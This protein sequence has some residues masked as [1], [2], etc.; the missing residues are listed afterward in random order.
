MQQIIIHNP[1]KYWNI[2]VKGIPASEVPKMVTIK[3]WTTDYYWHSYDTSSL[4]WKPFGFVPEKIIIE[5]KEKDEKMIKDRYLEDRMK[6]YNY[7]VI[8]V[9]DKNLHEFLKEE[10]M[11]HVQEPPKHFLDH[12]AALA[13]HNQRVL[14]AAF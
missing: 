13:H 4:H 3:P 11:L 5:L 14:W 2:R 8:N 7:N 1:R 12:Q 6:I 10:E 9:Y